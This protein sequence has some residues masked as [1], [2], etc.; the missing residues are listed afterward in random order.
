MM[1]SL[2]K[3]VRL[4]FLSVPLMLSIGCAGVFDYKAPVVVPPGALYQKTIAPLSF[5]TPFQT[6]EKIG[7]ARAESLTFPL[8]PILSLSYGDASVKTAAQNAGITKI[9]HVDYQRTNILGVFSTLE[10]FVY[11]E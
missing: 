10:V 5:K 9:H 4:F 3:W 1:T 11:G 8:Y 7:T 6:S 2:L